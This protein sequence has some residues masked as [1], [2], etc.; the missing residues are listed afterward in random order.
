MKK[1]V[2]RHGGRL[3]IESMLGRGTNV[4][5]WLPVKTQPHPDDVIVGEGTQSQ[6]KTEQHLGEMVK[7]AVQQ[8]D[9]KRV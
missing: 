8:E 1:I 6:S 4:M 5:M 2:E 3:T 9:A 7:R